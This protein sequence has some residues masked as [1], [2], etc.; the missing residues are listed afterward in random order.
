MTPA[1]TTRD[2]QAPGVVLSHR[3][4]SGQ[5]RTNFRL[6]FFTTLSVLACALALA[7]VAMAAAPSGQDQYLEQ[8]P[9]GGGNSNGNSGDT[10]TGTTTGVADT[11]GDGKI[12]EDEVKKAA[13]KNK[14]KKAQ[15]GATD[16]TGATGATGAAAG[17]T[18][19]PPAAESVAT[20]AKLGPFSQTTGLMIIGL[21]LIG[22]L[23]FFVFGN[24]A[25]GITSG[26]GGSAGKDATKPPA[27]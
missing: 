23:A 17:T 10:G 5:S 18:P 6:F 12:S 2:A 4:A 1:T 13:K 21:V 16:S 8:A 15:E 20:A 25:G 22:G 7:N 14:K 26:S 19:T 11:N 3:Q 27:R 24:G 9:N